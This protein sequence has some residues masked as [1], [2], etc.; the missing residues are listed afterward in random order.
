[1]IQVSDLRPDTH[2]KTDQASLSSFLLP[3]N[4]R[5]EVKVKVEAKSSEYLETLNHCDSF[6]AT[7]EAVVKRVQAY[8]ILFQKTRNKEHSK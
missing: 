8:R 3:V 5:I 2:G 7:A 1:M 6:P 4:I